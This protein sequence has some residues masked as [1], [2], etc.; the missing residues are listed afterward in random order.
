MTFNGDE[1]KYEFQC[2]IL[3]YLIRPA[4]AVQSYIVIH[5]FGSQKWSL[6]LL[7]Q[8][9]VRKYRSLFQYGWIN[10]TMLFSR[11]NWVDYVYKPNKDNSS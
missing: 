7:T 5:S 11:G 2:D 8:F 1:T 6:Q 3:Q 4:D 10:F 9:N